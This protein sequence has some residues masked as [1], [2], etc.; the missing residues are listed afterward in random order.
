MV[1]GL[2][3]VKA[4]ITNILGFGGYNSKPINYDEMPDLQASRQQP[5]GRNVPEQRR[6]A[7][8]FLSVQFTMCFIC[9]WLFFFMTP[10]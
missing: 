4:L 3:D 1:D 6:R 8:N 2:T 10:T 7:N 9:L 5:Q